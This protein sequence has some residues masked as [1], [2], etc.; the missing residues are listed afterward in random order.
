M[1]Y[2]FHQQR[3]LWHIDLRDLLSLD[4]LSIDV[5]R[6]LL[7]PEKKKSLILPTVTGRSNGKVTIAG[8]F[9]M[10]AADILSLQFKDFSGA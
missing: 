3:R 1:I 9:L 2:Y 10:T 6:K 5:E 4:C 7:L 8:Y